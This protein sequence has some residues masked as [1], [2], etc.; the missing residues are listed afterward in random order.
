MK[1][2]V[3]KLNQSLRREIATNFV[4]DRLKYDFE[5]KTEQLDA[6][7]KRLLEKIYAVNSKED[8]EYF[9]EECNKIKITTVLDN[10][11]YKGVVARDFENKNQNFQFTFDIYEK[12]NISFLYDKENQYSRVKNNRLDKNI[13]S[14]VKVRGCFNLTT[15]I[16]NLNKDISLLINESNTLFQ[17]CYTLLSKVRTV[18]NLL[19]H[20]SEAYKYIPENIEVGK[21]QHL[22]ISEKF[23]LL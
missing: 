10:I 9:V 15:E 18:D 22:S 21:P 14:F 19:V 11:H 1:K 20:W 3:I 16:Y 5:N 4:A 8:L 7:A 17:N 23:S 6:I 13:I 2:I 12:N